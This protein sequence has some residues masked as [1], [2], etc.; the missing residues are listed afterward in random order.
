MCESEECM[1]G[2]IRKLGRHLAKQHQQAPE[3]TRTWYLLTAINVRFHSPALGRRPYPEEFAQ[4]L[5]SVFQKQGRTNGSR[6]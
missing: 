2:L 3:Q 1:L 4:V 5:C 6:V